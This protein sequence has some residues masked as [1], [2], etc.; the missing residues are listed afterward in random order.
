MRSDIVRKAKSLIGKEFETNNSGK[1][2]IIDYKGIY[3]VTVMFYDPFVIVKCIFQ[4]LKAGR[5]KNPLLPSVYGRGYY[6][7]G[8]YSTNNIKVYKMWN[9]MLERCYD[10]KYYTTTSTYRDVEV[11]DEWLNFQ[12]FAAWCEVQEFFNV[13]D[14]KGK[15]YHLDKDILNRG[16]KIYS[17]ET[18]A[19]VPSEVNLLILN[20]SKVRGIYPVGV[21]FNVGCKKFVAHVGCHGKQKSLGVY[22]TPEEAFV[23]YKKA[24]ESYIKEVA[25]KWKDSVDDKVYESLMNWEIHIDD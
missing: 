24:K 19:F 7:V 15:S 14:N 16:S 9:R 25:E 8:K 10:E 2:F 17:P 13:K 6:G 12:N 1:C 18:C 22:E 5:V 3:D 21:Y 23:V 11:C 4:N 20:G